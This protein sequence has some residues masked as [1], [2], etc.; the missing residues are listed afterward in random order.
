MIILRVRLNSVP[1]P[2]EASLHPLTN[3]ENPSFGHTTEYRL[4]NPFLNSMDEI[5]T[6]FPPF[7]SES[8]AKELQPLDR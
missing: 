5:A 7:Q 1:S 8:C 2:P 4:T 3:Q 6:H